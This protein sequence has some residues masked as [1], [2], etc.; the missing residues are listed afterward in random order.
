MLVFIK[1]VL[2]LSK[3]EVM[4]VNKVKS[5]ITQPTF[6]S[7]LKLRPLSTCR[8]FLS[9]L[10]LECKHNPITLNLNSLIL[11]IF[12]K[13][14][15]DLFDATPFCQIFLRIQLHYQDVSMCTDSSYL[16]P[17]LL[18]YKQYYAEIEGKLPIF[19]QKGSDLIHILA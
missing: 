6:N 14:P 17:M 7:W 10:H 1:K 12:E 15:K 2:I 13:Y 18:Q 9:F 8:W 4:H 19:D 5:Y 16:I 11:V 3:C